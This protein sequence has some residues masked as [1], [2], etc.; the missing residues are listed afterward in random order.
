MPDPPLWSRVHLVVFAVRVVVP[1]MWTPSRTRP[2]AGTGARAGARA[3]ARTGARTGTSMVTEARVRTRV[4]TW[5]GTT[6]TLAARAGG[7]FL[8][9][10][11]D[12]FQN[13]VMRSLMVGIKVIAPPGTANVVECAF[14][15]ALLIGA[16]ARLRYIVRFG[17]R[18]RPR[19]RS[20]SRAR[21]RFGARTRAWMRAWTRAWTRV[22]RVRF[23]VCC[24][25]RL[26]WWDEWREDWMQHMDTWTHG[27]ISHLTSVTEHKHLPSRYLDM[28]WTRC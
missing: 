8:I 28:F 7:G 12:L 10:N 13:V 21:P 4:W 26:Q 19:T 2:A 24:C 16:G 22:F 14:A 11:A 27:L 25:H 17:I 1:A 20:S 15:S 6:P 3:G 5:T 9:S 23:V 18:A